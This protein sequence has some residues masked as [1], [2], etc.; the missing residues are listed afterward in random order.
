MKT[1]HEIVCALIA[2]MKE[3]DPYGYMDADVAMEKEALAK[4]IEAGRDAHIKER[5]FLCTEESNSTEEIES[6][7]QLIRQLDLY[8]MQKGGICHG[9]SG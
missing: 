6:A 2:F 4:E 9:I 5:L 1:L 7:C 3:Y 8:S